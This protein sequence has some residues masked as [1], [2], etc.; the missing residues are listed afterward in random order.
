MARCESTDEWQVRS[1]RSTSVCTVRSS[2]AHPQQLSCI[3][4]RSTKKAQSSRSSGDGAFASTTSCGTRWLYRA[5]TIRSTSS[6]RRCFWGSSF[7]LNSNIKFPPRQSPDSSQQTL[8][9]SNRPQFSSHN[10]LSNLGFLQW[11]LWLPHQVQ[12]LKHWTTKGW[13]SIILHKSR[14]WWRIDTKIL[15]L[16]EPNFS[17][18]ISRLRCLSY[19]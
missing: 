13:N 12:A 10:P 2:M 14:V 11:Q 6:A 8:L 17:L 16:Y 9:C 7:T 19:Y 5:H 18:K 1:R 15:Q 4:A 3:C